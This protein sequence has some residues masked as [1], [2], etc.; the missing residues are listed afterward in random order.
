MEDASLVDSR[1]TSA[2]NETSASA[3]SAARMAY[4][5][6]KFSSTGTLLTSVEDAAS[7][8][9]GPG[10]MQPSWGGGPGW[11][12]P[13]GVKEFG[14]DMGTLAVQSRQEAVTGLACHVQPLILSDVRSEALHLASL[15]GRGGTAW[16]SGVVPGVVGSEQGLNK[17]GMLSERAR[18]LYTTCSLNYQLTPRDR[19][20]TLQQVTSYLTLLFQ[21]TDLPSEVAVVSLIYLE[22]FLGRFPAA[23]DSSASTGL[24]PPGCKSGHSPPTSKSASLS[25]DTWRRALLAAVVCAAKVWDDCAVWNVDFV[26]GGGGGNAVSG[27]ASGVNDA[28]GAVECDVEDINALERFFLASLDFD[29]N[30]TP[31]EY[32]RSYFVIRS[33]GLR[34]KARTRRRSRSGKSRMKK[35]IELGKNDTRKE[36][37][38]WNSDSENNLPPLPSRPNISSSGGWNSTIVDFAPSE[39][40]G[41][42]SKYS[43]KQPNVT[44]PLPISDHMSVWREL[45][46]ATLPA[47]PPLPDLYNPWSGP[48]GYSRIGQNDGPVTLGLGFGDDRPSRHSAPE[49]TP[50]PSTTYYGEPAGSFALRSM[51]VS[52]ASSSSSTAAVAAPGAFSSSRGT[53]GP[54][55]SPR[56]RDILESSFRPLT[57]L[58]AA[59]LAVRD[60]ET[61]GGPWGWLRRTRRAFPTSPRGKSASRPTTETV[62]PVQYVAPLLPRRDY[63]HFLVRRRRTPVRPGQ[64]DRREPDVRDGM[65]GLW[66]FRKAQSE[67]LVVPGDDVRG[68]GPVGRSVAGVL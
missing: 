20:P 55:P 12:G 33:H 67:A 30:V 38:E 66:P 57:V 6:G 45:L 22:R 42:S 39:K 1:S 37:K 56:A 15:R 10:G 54:P 9:Y 58:D 3:T 24:P 36:Q 11:N 13:G 35:A 2:A 44:P 16:W 59:R 41:A 63:L 32:A 50:R 43:T 28:V 49:P 52:S 40:F 27:N 21:A 8:K 62:G 23:N 31:S 5:V 4:G 68:A 14:T 51:S 61:G 34:Q 18:P 60:D 47:L 25:G 65:I 26:G 46:P 7:A 48:P 19:P 29:V 53:E 17:D 64:P